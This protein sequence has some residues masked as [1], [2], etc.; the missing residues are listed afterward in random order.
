V[1]V[2]TP[3]RSYPSLTSCLLFFLHIPTSSPNRPQKLTFGH[4]DAPLIIYVGRLAVEK[5]L[6]LLPRILEVVPDAY[7]ALI[8]GGDLGAQWKARHGAD[9][10]VYCEAVYWSGEQLSQAYASS[11]V[12]VLPSNFEALG[13]VILEAMA[14]GVATVGCNAGGVP[15]M[16][17]HGVNGLLFESGDADGLANAVAELVH[18]Q[19]LRSKLAAEGKRYAEGISWEESAAYVASIYRRVISYKRQ[20]VV[21][22]SRPHPPPPLSPSLSNCPRCCRER[23]TPSP[24]HLRWPRRGEGLPSARGL[25][26]SWRCCCC[27]C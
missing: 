22:V 14:S 24:P 26:L 13:N 23:T 2:N 7:L 27:C 17:K 4:P 5:G 11:D 9:N 8:G 20:G 15:H 25:C 18:N 12:F 16:I 6:D 21:V 1:N 10:R 19:A 3:L